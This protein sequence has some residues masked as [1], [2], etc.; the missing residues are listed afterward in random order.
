MAYA[1]FCMLRF[2][3]IRGRGGPKIDFPI[4]KSL[5]GILYAMFWTFFSIGFNYFQLLPNYKI[6][7]RYGV[8]YV[9]DIFFCGFQLLSTT[10][11]LQ[12][13]VRIDVYLLFFN[14]FAFFFMFFVFF[15]CFFLFFWCCWDE[16]WDKNFFCLACRMKVEIKSA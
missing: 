9:L 14:G 12:T 10:P 8:R 5:G 4:T 3:P 7:W 2:G 11:Q 6:A 15:L 1:M 13:G 16:K